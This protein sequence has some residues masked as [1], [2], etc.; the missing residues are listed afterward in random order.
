MRLEQ[1]AEP[2]DV[3]LAVLRAHAALADRRIDAIALG[4][5]AAALAQEHGRFDVA[6]EALL[7]VGYASRRHG[8]SMARSALNQALS[9][10][11]E[12]QLAVWQVR[13][14][15]ELGM[16]DLDVD[17]DPTRFYQARERATAAGMVGMLAAID[18]HIGETIGTAQRVCCR[19][20]HL[21]GCRYAGPAVTTDGTPRPYSRAHRRV[22]AQ[23]R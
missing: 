4:Q 15:A 18:L 1:L 19:V 2:T 16:L 17:S 5:R 9:L 3:D 7:V 13:I 12:H 20:P 6:C 22:P 8:T 23:C 21:S 11:E 14:L 10:S